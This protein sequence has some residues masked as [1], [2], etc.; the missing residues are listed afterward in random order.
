MVADDPLGRN[1]PNL[2]DF[3]SIS[4]SKN[5][6]QTN[7]PQAQQQKPFNQS[8]Q[9]NLPNNIPSL[10]NMNFTNE[11]IRRNQLKSSSNQFN[12]NANK[13]NADINNRKNPRKI[14]QT[15]E[16][17]VKLIEIFPYSE[18]DIKKLLTRFPHEYDV[19]FFTNKILAET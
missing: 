12:N 17:F 13:V 1:G 14:D 18:V 2:N 10:L 7:K 3:L 5:Y 15:N 19:M 6:N 11:E 16:L 8:N 9:Q 4:K